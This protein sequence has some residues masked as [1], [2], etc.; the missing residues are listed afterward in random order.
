MRRLKFVFIGLLFSG[1]SVCASVAR[2]AAEPALTGSPAFA[3][4][5]IAQGDKITVP[6]TTFPINPTVPGTTFPIK[7]ADKFPFDQDLIEKFFQT[8]PFSVNPHLG[9]TQAEEPS[10]RTAAPS[11][12][13]ISALLVAISRLEALKQLDDPELAKAQ[14]VSRIA[15][16]ASLS[17]EYAHLGALRD[18]MRDAFDWQRRASDVTLVLVVVV[19]LSG[20][21]LSFYEILSSVRRAEAAAKRGVVGDSGTSTL[22]LSPGQLQVTSAITGVAILALSLGFLYLFL[23]RVYQV[24]VISS[25]IVADAHSPAGR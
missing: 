19:T 16:Y 9:A 4:E 23:D 6:G 13:A 14:K 17:D 11:D 5:I 15:Y 21:G 1:L 12:S 7:P 2:E 20:V 10:K 3:D 18:R 22:T 24:D 8:K 25:S